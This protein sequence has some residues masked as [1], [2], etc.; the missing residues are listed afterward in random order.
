MATYSVWSMRPLCAQKKTVFEAIR[1]A[2]F[3]TNSRRLATIVKHQT[4]VDENIKEKLENKDVKHK[5]HEGVQGVGT[6]I[7]PKILV[8]SLKNYMQGQPVKQLQPHAD[9][10]ARYLWCRKR[11]VEETDIKKQAREYAEKLGVAD[12]DEDSEIEVPKES[13]KKMTTVMRKLKQHLYN[14]QPIKY[15]ETKPMTYLLARLAPNYAVTYR[16]LNEIKKRVPDFRPQA[17]L[18]FG[19]GLGSTVWATD[20]LWK[21]SIQ[22][23]YCVDTSKDMHNLAEDILCGGSK[24]ENKPYLDTV[25]FRHFLPI[26]SRVTFDLTVSAYALL[27]LPNKQERLKTIENLWNK[28][29][30]FLVLIEN[31]TFEGFLA[32]MEARD[33][34]MAQREKEQSVDGEDRLQEE[35]NT[36]GL[37][38]QVGHVFAPCQHDHACPVLN[39]GTKVPCNFEQKFFSELLGNSAVPSRERFSYI[40][41]RK[42]DRQTKDAH[43][44]RITQPVMPRSKHVVCQLCCANGQLEQATI[45]KTKHGRDLYR[46]ART[47][48]WGDLLPISRSEGDMLPVTEQTKSDNKELLHSIEMNEMEQSENGLDNERTISQ[49]GHSNEQVNEIVAHDSPV[50]RR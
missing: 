11:P 45:T 20:V 1:R 10:M 22:Q 32:L 41:L 6:V 49:E 31:G 46:C 2:R 15:D 7:L 12:I 30:Q 48:S 40:V 38:T 42:G 21:N 16:V 47:S 24:E 9:A 8:K 39:K 19:S 44:P 28:T 27:E 26:G 29:D 17:V 14:W 33:F 34:V 36:L 50:E 23:F 37:N 43:W 35:R 5:R 18:D 3:E 25:F 4:R 13:K